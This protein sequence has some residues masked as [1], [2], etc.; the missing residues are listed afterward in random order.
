MSQRKSS[1]TFSQ[2]PREYMVLRAQEEIMRSP[3]GNTRTKVRLQDQVI[4]KDCLT[5]AIKYKS[6]KTTPLPKPSL[7]K[8]HKVSVI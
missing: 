5:L 1:C 3:A 6:I 4:I 2:E 7:S 8:I